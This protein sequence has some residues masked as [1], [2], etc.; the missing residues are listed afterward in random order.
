MG[1]KF[2]FVWN[3]KFHFLDILKTWSSHGVEREIFEII[4]LIITTGYSVYIDG[5]KSKHRSV[6]ME[7]RWS[8]ISSAK[9]RY[10]TPVA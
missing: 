6:S 4:I 1:I 5:Y 3:L 2:Y 8:D 7:K 10:Q 9:H